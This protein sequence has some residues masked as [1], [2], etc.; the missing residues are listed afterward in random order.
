MRQNGLTEL[1][2]I[3]IDAQDAQDFFFEVNCPVFPGI[4]ESV[5]DHRPR[6]FS[7]SSVPS[8]L[9]CA[10]CASMFLK[11]FVYM[12]EQDIQDF[13]SPTALPRN[14]TLSEFSGSADLPLQL[15][16]FLLILCILCIDVKF[17]ILLN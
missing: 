5:T 16:L 10:S 13:L 11:F 3:N 7:C 12:D 17:L 9:S 1:I 8:C 14:Q 15:L 4:R 6:S 2:L